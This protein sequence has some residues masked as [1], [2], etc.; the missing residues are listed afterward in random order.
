FDKLPPQVLP[1]AV[2]SWVEN[3]GGAPEGRHLVRGAALWAVHAGK[4]LPGLVMS[5]SLVMVLVAIA[6]AL[7]TR[8][9]MVV[10]LVTCLV[11]Y[12]LANLMPVLVQTT[13][14][15][16]ASVAGPVQKLLYFMAQ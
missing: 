3:L 15:A 12:F 14:P 16:R 5:C 1:D 4:V 11:V 7:A 13:R 2:G 10:N 9:P 8:L 6:V